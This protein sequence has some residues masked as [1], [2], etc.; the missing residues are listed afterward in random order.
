MASIYF[1]LGYIYKIWV[2]PLNRKSCSRTPSCYGNQSLC[3][4]KQSSKPSN[5]FWKASW[6]TVSP[7]LTSGP[8]HMSQFPLQLSQKL[9]ATKHYTRISST[10]SSISRR[11]FHPRC[12]NMLKPGMVEVIS[13][14]N[15]KKVWMKIYKTRRQ[16]SKNSPLK[17]VSRKAPSGSSV[18][19]AKAPSNENPGKS[20]PCSVGRKVNFSKLPTF[21]SFWRCRKIL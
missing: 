2:R 12:K 14:K 18:M 21:Q 19:K 13:L 7:S 1:H 15:S 16:P 10:A 8:D 5:D 17:S 20:L 9:P 11:H 3:H 6:R 4:N